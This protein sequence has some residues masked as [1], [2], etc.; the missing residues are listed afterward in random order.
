[1]IPSTQAN[2]HSAE[3]SACG[4]RFHGIGICPVLTEQDLDN[5]GF[6]IQGYYQGTIRVSTNCRLDNPLPDSVRYLSNNLVPYYLAGKASQSCL[7]SFVVSPEFPEEDSSGL[8]IHSF[9]GHLWI[10]V[11]NAGQSFM[12][13]ADKVA[14]GKNP[15]QIAVIPDVGDASQVQV[16][17]ESSLCGVQPNPV[18]LPVENGILNIPLNKFIDEVGVKTCVLNG[19]AFLPSGPLRIS[20]FIDGYDTKFLPL[21][22][23]AIVQKDSKIEISGDENVSV[24]ALDSDFKIDREAIFDFDPARFHVLRLLTIHGRSVIGEYDPVKGKWSWIY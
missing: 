21:P 1:V 15:T 13:F 22:I 5:V 20:W 18:N 7:I 19:V 24:I 2:Y 4:K 9:V 10:R 17:F 23:P 6:A 12:G 14:A 3:F 11:L 16:A 8:V